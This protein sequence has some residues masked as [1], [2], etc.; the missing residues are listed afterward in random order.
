MFKHASYYK[1]RTFA[2][3]I[4]PRYVSLESLELFLIN[5]YKDKIPSSAVISTMDNLSKSQKRK[6]KRHGVMPANIQ[7]MLLDHG[8]KKLKPSVWRNIKNLKND[9]KMKGN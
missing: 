5:H 9:N 3:N 6:F 8:I 4:K 7:R 2:D 1:P